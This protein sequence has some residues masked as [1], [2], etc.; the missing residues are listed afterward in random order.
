[1]FSDRP[2]ISATTLWFLLWHSRRKTSCSLGVNPHRSAMDSQRRE[3]AF[4]SASPPSR[5]VVA[6]PPVDL[7]F[8]W[9][10]GAAARAL[11]EA[12]DGRTAV[13][14][15]TRAKPNVRTTSAP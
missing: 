14:A 3:R 11:P 10:L 13:T 7:L 5:P 12:R 1:M 15:V 6:E 2:G 9:L 4:E 8:L